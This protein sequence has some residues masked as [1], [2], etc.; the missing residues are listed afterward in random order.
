ML[1]VGVSVESA[2]LVTQDQF[3]RLV[4]TVWLVT[5]GKRVNLNEAMLRDG[6]AWA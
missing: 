3:K 4:A 1:A 6:H 2:G 5:D